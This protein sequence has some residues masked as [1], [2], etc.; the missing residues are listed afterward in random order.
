MK[1]KQKSIKKNTKNNL[2]QPKLTRLREA[3]DLSYETMI[4]S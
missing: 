3:H 1:L 4:I 2:S